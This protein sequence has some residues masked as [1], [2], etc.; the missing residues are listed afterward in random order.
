MKNEKYVEIK[1]STLSDANSQRVSKV[2]EDLCAFLINKQGIDTKINK[3]TEKVLK[4]LDSTPIMISHL[5]T[6]LSHHRTVS[7]FFQFGAKE[8]YESTI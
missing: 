1:R 6:L 7:E 8:S 2:F 3:N 5:R 4:I